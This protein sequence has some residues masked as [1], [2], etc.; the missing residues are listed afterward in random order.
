MAPSLPVVR[1]QRLSQIE[2]FDAHDGVALRIE[3]DAAVEHL[4]AQRVLLQRI[5][6]FGEGM[7]DQVRE[8]LAKTR[9]APKR[10]A[11]QHFFKCDLDGVRGWL[12][13]AHRNHLQRELT[14]FNFSGNTQLD[15]AAPLSRA[16]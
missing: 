10:G 15:Q 1:A 9:A 12:E 4:D 13:V 7:L 5:A 6:V 8:Q 14:Q 3:T 11:R 2:G 16:L